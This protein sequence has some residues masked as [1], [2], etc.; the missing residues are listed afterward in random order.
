[1]NLQPLREMLKMLYKKIVSLC[2]SCPLLSRRRL[3]SSF[4]WP[5]LASRAVSHLVIFAL[6]CLLLFPC[7]ILLVRSRLPRSSGSSTVSPSAAFRPDLNS[8]VMA[9]V[10]QVSVYLVQSIRIGLL[11]SCKLSLTCRRPELRCLKIVVPKF[12]TSIIVF[13]RFCNLSATVMSLSCE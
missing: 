2:G 4:D 12:A 8:V 10:F 6:F 13:I 7:C 1:M 3:S 5:V 9:L 11:R